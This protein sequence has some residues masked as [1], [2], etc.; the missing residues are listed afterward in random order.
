MPKSSIQKLFTVVLVLN[1]VISAGCAQLS[2]ERDPQAEIGFIDINSDMKLR[3]MIVHNA[4]DRKALCSSC[5]AFLRLCMPGS[6][7]P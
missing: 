3:R 2:R 4:R 1:F 5:M 6:T 7:S